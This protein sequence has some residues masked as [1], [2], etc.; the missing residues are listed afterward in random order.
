[1]LAEKVFDVVDCF[2]QRDRVGGIWNYSGTAQ[3]S[4]IPIP[5][6]DP[7]YGLGKVKEVSR[8]SRY[9]NG[10]EESQRV[11]EFETPLYDNLETNI[12]HF[13][14]AYSDK[15]FPTNAPLFPKHGMVLEYLQEYAEDVRSHIRFRTQV[16]D[17]QLQ[18]KGSKD[19]W[20]ISSLDLISMNVSTSIYDAVVVANGHYTVPHVPDIKGV[21]KWNECYPGLIVHS[22]AYRDPEVYKGK[23]VLVIGDSASGVDIAAQIGHFC[24]KP[25]LLS[26]RSASQFGQSTDD[27]KDDVPEVIEF[28][29][30]TKHD[31]A[32]RYSDGS[33]EAHVEA[34]VFATGYFYSFP[35]LSNLEAPIITDGLRTRD[36]YQ[37]MFHID[38]PTLAFPVLNLKVIPFPLAENQCA[39][40]AR[41]WSGRLSLPSKAEMRQWETATIGD[42]GNG[43]RFHVLQFPLDAE[44]LNGLH[45]W[46]GRAEKCEGLENSGKG[47]A[48]KFWD[49]REIWM[50]SEFPAI[51]KA[52]AERGDGRFKIRTAEQLGFEYTPG[53]QEQGD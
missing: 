13:L 35:F 32:I 16:T 2:E 29:D 42:R 39:V 12:P 20:K 30:P 18:N 49:P 9:R 8:E 48:G 33:L 50:R 1:M 53:T 3:S 25:L 7:R 6:T 34:V 5:Q 23:K 4:Q 15:P 40:I 22:K 38:H 41:V 51:K 27:W 19:Q 37:H 10:R 17:V 24:K 45:D 26:S 21:G 31:R 43:K 36:V 44:T 52:Y 11:S 28:L 47:K 46:A 14:M